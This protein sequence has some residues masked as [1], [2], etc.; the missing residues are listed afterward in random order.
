MNT[1]L[2][3]SSINSSN[4]I[5]QVIPSENRDKDAGFNPS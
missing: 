2:N 5:I 3:I 4:T 1:N